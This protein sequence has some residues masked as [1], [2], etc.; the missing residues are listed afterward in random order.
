MHA[1]AESLLLLLFLKWVLH[2]AVT[3]SLHAEPQFLFNG[4]CEERGGGL[5]CSPVWIV[6]RS[7][8]DIRAVCFVVRGQ[9]YCE[10]N[11]ICLLTNKSSYK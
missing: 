8:G 5:F 9:L 4:G 10:N 11:N 1:R 6:M 7:Y 3:N 2:V